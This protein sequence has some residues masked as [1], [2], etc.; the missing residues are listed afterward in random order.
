MACNDA[1]CDFKPMRLRRRALGPRDIVIDM[2]YCG[3][4]HTDLHTAADHLPIKTRYPCVPGHELAG[5]A[6]A[7]GADVRGV[8]VGDPVGV[9]CLVDSCL[10]CAACEEGR[11]N[12]CRKRVGTYGGED[13]SGRA[14]CVPATART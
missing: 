2:K 14:R 12:L 10:E 9:G 5:I 13:T 1:T 8:A 4:C 11:E 6:V 7:V 3:I